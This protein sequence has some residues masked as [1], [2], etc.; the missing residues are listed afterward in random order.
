MSAQHVARMLAFQESQVKPP[1]FGPGIYPGVDYATY[2]QIKAA[3]VSMLSGFDRSPAHAREQM[4]HGRES[5]A[6]DFGTAYH[7]AVLEP[8]RYPLAFV[9]GLED[10]DRRFKVEK[11]RYAAFCEQNRGRTVLDP[12]EWDRIEAMKVVL[13][14]HETAAA[15]LT[16]EGPNE[17]VAVWDDKDTGER[18]KG[19]QDA[20]RAYLG[21]TWI[22]DIK[23][24]TDASPAGWAREVAK[25]GYAEQA[26][27]YLDGLYALQP[28]ERRFV[29]IAQE[30]EPPFAVAVHE[31]D[32]ATLAEGRRRY[33]R[34]LRAYA[35]AIRTDQWPAY[36]AGLHQT[37]L[38][39]W[40]ITQEESE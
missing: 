5:K 15:F 2:A 26:A 33:R 23:S 12:E 18:C 19:R 37:T 39:K 32:E 14:S 17:V 4:L 35:E 20:L 1:T 38:P 28:R 24:T 10:N 6:L 7:C 3:R 13:F 34:H 30:K 8:E 31:P 22:A 29:W 11:E 25:W 27:F 16:A 21:W 36:P 9:R 40:E